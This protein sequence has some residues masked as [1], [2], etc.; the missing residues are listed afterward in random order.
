MNK[1]CSGYFG[2][3]LWKLTLFLIPVLLTGCYEDKEGCLD[4]RAT[5]FDP[6]ADIYC[7][8]QPIEDCCNYP[9]LQLQIQHRVVVNDTTAYRLGYNDSIYYDVA[10]QPFRIRNIQYY[11]SNFELLRSDG[12]VL[13][14]DETLEIDLNPTG[15]P[16]LVTFIP[17][18]LLVNAGISPTFSVGDFRETGQFDKLRFN[19]GLYEDLNRLNARDFPA[20]NPLAVQTDTM[21]NFQDGR[22]YYSKTTLFQDTVATDTIPRVVTT[23][24]NDGTIPVE[25]DL[26][27]DF[28]HLE[29]FN[30]LLTLR[31]DYLVWFA[32]VDVRNDTEEE[33]AAKFVQQIADAFS[34][35]NIESK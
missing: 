21:Y 24:L 29:G 16:E 7:T 1:V 6:S 31:V 30:L 8:D 2:E 17:D 27:S 10:D 19:V 28:N 13:R 33:I 25:I 35:V 34:F 14:I 3:S 18:W 9:N 22:Y 12:T 20:G 23:D 32:N 11:L 26:P 15:D 4:I 5:N